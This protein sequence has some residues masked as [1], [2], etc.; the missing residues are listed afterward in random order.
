MS[1]P[2]AGV[3]AS[4][5]RPPDAP[6]FCGAQ[7]VIDEIVNSF[8]QAAAPDKESAGTS[9]CALNRQRRIAPAL[10]RQRFIIIVAREFD[11]M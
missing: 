10:A 4:Q 1:K 7:W 8:I 6:N 5:W 2:A 3:N 11:C 9:T